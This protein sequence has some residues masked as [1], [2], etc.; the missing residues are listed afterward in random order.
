MDF[1]NLCSRSTY[2]SNGTIVFL[3]APRC[4]SHNSLIFPRGERRSIALLTIIAVFS[5]LLFIALTIGIKPLE[6]FLAK[7]E[8]FLPGLLLPCFFLALLIFLFSLTRIYHDFP[9]CLAPAAYWNPLTP[10]FNVFQ[11][12]KLIFI[13][14]VCGTGLAMGAFESCIIYYIERRKR[15]KQ[16]KA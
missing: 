15:I 13:F 3:I 9:Y 14:Q 6:T 4:C 11:Y 1:P 2:A 5:V 10:A 7:K 16:R 12:S 8:S